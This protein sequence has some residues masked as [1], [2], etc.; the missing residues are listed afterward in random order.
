MEKISGHFAMAK[1]GRP[2]KEP[3]AEDR[4]K[5]KELLA[6]KAPITDLA[7][8][9]GYSAPTFRKY[10]SV[11]IFTVKKIVEKSRP[12]RKVTDEMREKVKRYIGCKMAPEKV[13]LAMGYEAP[14]DFEDFKADF[15]RELAVGQAVYR[16]KVLDRLDAQMTG[17]MVGATNKLEALTQITDAGDEP[18]SQSAAYVGKKAAASA[19][20]ANAAAA[21]GG[22]FAPPP[23][24]I[25]GRR[26]S[27]R[28][29]R[30]AGL[31]RRGMV[32]SMS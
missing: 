12:V 19:A 8:L 24:E 7:K 14:E 23:A 20:A 6:D 26:W 1:R 29:P 16:A 11:E 10:F 15:L 25:G 17:G 13:A 3:S 18:Q 4:A 27:A 28:D 30:R 32:D 31:V 21:A 22:K 2:T 9:F 5:V